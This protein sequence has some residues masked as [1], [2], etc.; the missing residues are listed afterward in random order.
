VTVSVTLLGADVGLIRQLARARAMGLEGDLRTLLRV[1]LWPVFGAGIAAAIAVYGF[2]PQLAGILVHGANAGGAVRFIR[3]LAPFLPLAAVS[4]AALGATRG[5]GSMT[6]YNLVENLGKPLA[7]PLL[8]LAAIAMGLSGAWVALGWALPVVG[9]L[10]ATLFVLFVMLRRATLSGAAQASG[11]TAS[12]A[13]TGRVAREF[14]SFAAPRWAGAVFQ[15]ALIWLD[16]LL[17]GAMRSTAEAGVYATAS[18]FITAGTF[19]LQAVGFAIAPQIGS[20]LARGERMAS[21]RLYQVATWWLVIVSWPLYLTLGIFAPLVLGVFGRGFGTGAGAMTILAVATL[22]NVGTGNVTFVLLMAGKSWWN[23]ANQ[24]AALAVNVGLNL[25]LIPKLG[26]S[27][28]ALAW[29]AAILVENG[30]PLIQVRRHL[31]LHP[32]GRGYLLVTGAAVACYALP[33]IALRWAFG[34]GLAGLTATLVAGTAAYAMVLWRNRDTLELPALVAALS[35]GHA[36]HS[37][38]R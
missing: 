1:S 38:G 20:L 11:V 37:G 23:L 13:S 9:G 29:G 7:R 15:I 6:P 16:V 14:W 2:A 21:E 17:V 30:L 18:R 34:P 4:T 33:G 32:F 12:T 28:A 26:I 25:L 22:V 5:L 31:G 10:A 35:Q 8:I 19:A 36:G 27:G 3:V 24:G